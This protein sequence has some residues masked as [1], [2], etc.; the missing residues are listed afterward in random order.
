[1]IVVIDV[2]AACEIVLGRPKADSVANVIA[3]ADRVIAPDLFFSEAANVFWKL[4]RFSAVPV[5]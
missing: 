5:G 4:Y 3:E 2:C 1:M